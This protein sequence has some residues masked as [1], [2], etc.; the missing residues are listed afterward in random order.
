[1]KSIIITLGLLVG[2]V[3]AQSISLDRIVNIIHYPANQKAYS[4]VGRFPFD[5]V[6]VPKYCDEFK[7]VVNTL[8]NRYVQIKF[9]FKKKKVYTIFQGHF[10]FTVDSIT[11]IK[12]LNEN[13]LQ[14]DL[15]VESKEKQ[16]KRE[17]D[18]QPGEI[19]T[20][21]KYIVD[22]KLNRVTYNYNSVWNDK[23]WT[24]GAI[25]ESLGKLNVN[26]FQ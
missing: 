3:F 9:D 21:E 23:F 19:V 6:L 12:V 25:T 10:Y 11:S 5:S 26:I 22:F 2:Q 4:R 13:T 17:Y 20:H 15:F 14:V 24:G 7:P 1:M 8:N 16:L 18:R